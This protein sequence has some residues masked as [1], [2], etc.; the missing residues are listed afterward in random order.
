MDAEPRNIPPST[1]SS[2]LKLKS[3]A[4]QAEEEEKARKK[5]LRKAKKLAKLKAKENR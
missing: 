3:F 1:T 5:A 2:R 4:L